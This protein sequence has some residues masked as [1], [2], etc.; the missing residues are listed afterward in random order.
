MYHRHHGSTYDVTAVWK[1]VLLNVAPSHCYNHL[2]VCCVSVAII[3]LSSF[4]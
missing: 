4:R 2:V 3:R 1:P